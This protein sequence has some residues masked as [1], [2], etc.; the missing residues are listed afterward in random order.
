MKERANSFRSHSGSQT[1]PGDARKRLGTLFEIPGFRPR[2]AAL[3]LVALALAIVVS[4]SILIAP[5]A[6]AQEEGT[7]ALSPAQ[8]MVGVELTATLAD[9]D[10]AISAATWVW[11]SSSDWDASAETGTGTWSDSSG[12]TSASYTPVTGDVG[13]Y[14]RATVSYTDG[15]GPGK[16]AQGVVAAQVNNPLGRRPS[17]GRDDDD[18][19]RG[20]ALTPVLPE[21]VSAIRELAENSVAGAMVGGPLST[22]QSEGCRSPIALVG[23]TPPFQH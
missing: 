15:Q 19:N 9:P 23:K 17:S 4:Y 21:G 5:F 13:K 6:L 16:S 22:T 20:V 7:V 3:I 2:H 10:G 12:A 8:P 18:D 11:A 1:H 14:L